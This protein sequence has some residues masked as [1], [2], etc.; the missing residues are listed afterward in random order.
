MF[1]GLNFPHPPYQI[2]QKYYDLITESNLQQRIPTI[3][4]TDGKPLIA[5]PHTHAYPYLKALQEDTSQV[6]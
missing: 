2:E 5:H 3:K 1:V 4:D 6:L